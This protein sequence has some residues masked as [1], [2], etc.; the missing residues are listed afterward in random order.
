MNETGLILRTSLPALVAAW[1]QSA[2]E[3]TEAFRL[4]D[5]AR[6]RLKTEFGDHCYGFGFE[7]TRSLHSNRGIDTSEELLKELKKD[8]WRILVDRMELRRVLSI[9]RSEE[10][11]K[12]L[13]TGDGLPDIEETQILAMLEGTFNSVGIYIEEAVKEVFDYLRP[14]HSKYKTNSEFEI[15]NRVIL[16]WVVER[17]YGSTWHIDYHR[18]TNL[19]AIDNVFHALDGNGTIKTNRGPLIDAINALPTTENFGETQYF[20]FRC[21]KNHNLHLEFKRLDLVTK[22]NQVAGGMRL[23]QP[24]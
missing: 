8:A 9:K 1:K 4:L 14:A 12:Q 6:T 2:T 15:G 3:I 18:E 5:S 22:L 17:G 16:G 10:L 7:V 20:K 19:R 21:N 23:R 24:A 11:N 13:E